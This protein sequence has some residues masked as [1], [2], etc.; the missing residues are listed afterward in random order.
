M[1]KKFIAGCLFALMLT[2]S[3]FAMPEIPK[4]FQLSQPEAFGNAEI[5]QYSPVAVREYITYGGK[6]Q[7][8]YPTFEN[9]KEALK[10]LEQRM[11]EYFSILARE[12]S[13]QALSDETL[14]DYE[15]A[16]YS[17]VNESNT[18][19]K[20]CF[21]EFVNFLDIYMSE[22]RNEAIKR[23]IRN[24]QAD[25]L[26]IDSNIEEKLY[27]L[28]PYTSDFCVEYNEKVLLNSRLQNGGVTPGQQTLLRAAAGDIVYRSDIDVFKAREYAR[29]H[30]EDPNTFDYHYFN[31]GD[32]ANFAS[33][34]L[35]A[36]G[37]TQFVTNDVNTGWWH[38]QSPGGLT[39]THSFSWSKADNFA[40]R[41]GVMYSTGSHQY[42][43]KN[44]KIGD[45][46]LLDHNSNGTWDHVAFVTGTDGCAENHGGYTYKDY[47]VAQHT[48]NYIAWTS[49]TIRNGWSFAGLHGDSY[50]IIRR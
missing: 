40:R 47:E 6:Q 3:A 35:E 45:F 38:K 1:L 25:V 36:G 24:S 8:L 37:A 16:A 19:E 42:F 11:P 46:I 18:E 12:A 50:G 28:L 23:L 49:N 29:A 21:D 4:N 13:L 15:L 2:G 10:N 14:A 7:K 44:V 41:L 48:E 34:I 30:A 20:N 39:H 33:Q 22:E 17:R 31:N 32:C 9:Q 5:N 27:Y 26:G 43:A